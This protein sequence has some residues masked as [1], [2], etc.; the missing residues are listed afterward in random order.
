[1][2]VPFCFGAVAGAIATGRVPDGGEAGDSVD[3]YLYDG[4]TSRAPLVVAS[5]LGGIGSLV[6]VLRGSYG[7]ARVAGIGAV[8]GIVSAWGAAQWPYVV[9]TSMK[10]A[11]TAAPSGT[12]A[13]VLVAFG[14]ACV[15][16]LPA[17]A[18]LFRLDQ[19][20]LLPEEGGT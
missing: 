19:Q 2:L 1:L 17:L 7:W 3:S 10:I 8:G 13:A 15:I 6:L 11:E 20:G 5:A 18:L 16:V 12:L 4:L 9:P 14:L